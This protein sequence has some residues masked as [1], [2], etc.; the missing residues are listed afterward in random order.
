MDKYKT[1]LAD[2]GEKR[3]LYKKFTS[4]CQEQIFDFIEKNGF[5]QSL[6]QISCRTKDITSLEQKLK[7]EKVSPK[8]LKNVRDLSGVRLVFFVDEVILRFLNLA[9]IENRIGILEVVRYDRGYRNPN[10]LGQYITL[11]ISD[12]GVVN[13]PHLK[14]FED[15]L[16]ELQVTDSL[17]NVWSSIYHQTIYKNRRKLLE[18]APEELTKL[19]ARY[20]A[21][22]EVPLRQ[23]SNNINYLYNSGIKLISGIS[24]FSDEVYEQLESCYSVDQ[25]WTILN[26]INEQLRTFG[27]RFNDNKRLFQSIISIFKRFSFTEET[28]PIEQPSWILDDI[29][30]KFISISAGLFY[31]LPE[32]VCD[33]FEELLL[34]KQQYV[35]LI[36]EHLKV[37]ACFDSNIISQRGYSYHLILANWI[38]R[39]SS[40]HNNMREMWINLLTH[41]LRLELSG[42]SWIQVD[43]IS[44]QLGAP[45]YST[46]L[47]ELRARCINILFS[48]Y[49]E[50]INPKIRILLIRVVLQSII[51]SF[52]PDQL[53]QNHRLMYE[54][55]SEYIT[56]RFKKMRSGMKLAEKITLETEVKKIRYRFSKDGYN[57]K[58]LDKFL[59][60]GYQTKDY[61]LCRA[62]V[63]KD[64][65]A[66]YEPQDLSK[67]ILTLVASISP[68]SWPVWKNRICSIG[69]LYPL[70][71]WEEFE[72]YEEFLKILATTKP[73][74]ALEL[75]RDC[76]NDLTW[77]CRVLISIVFDS[78]FRSELEDLLLSYIEKDLLQEAI[79][80]GLFQI[81]APPEHF[82]EP[83][84]SSLFRKNNLRLLSVLVC[85]LKKVVKYWDHILIKNSFFRCV[86]VLSNHGSF[87]WVRSVLLFNDHPVIQLLTKDEC[88]KLLN[89]L[90]AMEHVDECVD[91]LLSIVAKNM[92]EESLKYFLK[93]RRNQK[94]SSKLLNIWPGRMVKTI[95]VLNE[96]SITELKEFYQELISYEGEEKS[97]IFRLLPLLLNHSSQSVKQLIEQFTIDDKINSKLIMEILE[98]YHGDPSVF[99]H[100]KKIISSAGLKNE[101]LKA[102]CSQLIFVKEWCEKGGKLAQLQFRKELINSWTSDDENQNIK[103]FLKIFNEAIDTAIKDEKTRLSREVFFEKASFEDKL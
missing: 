5:K 66:L 2:Y 102:I 62:L 92:P 33:F 85:S 3:N 19:E 58:A 11:K 10:F 45:P 31:E 46:E 13:N 76:A 56:C 88:L 57:T 60:T 97:F 53:T 32:S 16:C 43:K 77:F 36:F 70:L 25:I 12:E 99:H 4:L 103:K 52:F 29:I 74:Y 82:L 55:E 28:D 15:F 80:Q 26:R 40:Q 35:H 27:P 23:V 44:I 87:G 18:I 24:I 95:D 69:R 90:I 48:N 101:E 94:E 39:I 67:K 22:I 17:Q 42:T 86:E 73:E 59:S 7:E 21:L 30:K 41:L 81:N 84:L 34:Q 63:G 91:C 71:D 20:N 100:Y 75:L 79:V 14:E 93:R 54:K 9:L 89:L 65:H 98:Q 8:R 37:L 68:Q 1:L 96:L 72:A 83:V 61:L 6:D 50:E 49:V 47:E 38:E 64:Y 51:P 78:S